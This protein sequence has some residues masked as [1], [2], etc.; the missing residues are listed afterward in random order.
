MQIILTTLD[1]IKAFANIFL[2]FS[3]DF[4]KIGFFKDFWIRIFKESD[5]FLVLPKT[6]CE[7]V[8]RIVF[9]D[10][11]SVLVISSLNCLIFLT[12]F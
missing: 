2:H 3:A 9:L 11:R 7:D 4:K 8:A 12:P 1:D 10:L 5:F 6:S